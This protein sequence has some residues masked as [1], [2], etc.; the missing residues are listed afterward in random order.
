MGRFTR[1]SEAALRQWGYPDGPIEISYPFEDYGDHK[2]IVVR[3]DYLVDSRYRLSM[4][5]DTDIDAE[6]ASLVRVE[7][8]RL[9]L[10]SQESS[11]EECGLARVSRTFAAVPQDHIE[12][13]AQNVQLFGLN[14]PA[15]S[16]QRAWVSSSLSGGYY[17]FNGI[18]A[19]W[20]GNSLL[21]S[22][23]VGDYKSYLNF[24]VYCT[25][26]GVCRIKESDA[27]RYGIYTVPQYLTAS[28]YQNKSRAAR[29]AT[30]D[31][32]TRYSY[33]LLSSADTPLVLPQK[34]TPF[35]RSDPGS[36]GTSEITVLSSLT[37]PTADEYLAM[38]DAHEA[39][40]YADAT[41][42]KWMG[43]IYEIAAPY[44]FA[45]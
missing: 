26:E 2:S 25:P 27:P 31:G 6:T 37:V 19:A 23:P 14:M 5:L 17:Y 40:Q 3:R 7:Y 10:V 11:G 30:V 41:V 9:L 22:F 34:L 24:W 13:G 42:T 45:C 29:V 4:P 15:G 44:V 35:Y 28:W 18:P 43:N 20:R 39:Y 38:A 1:I 33:R 12:R 32:F 8:D 21:M 36:A 16:W